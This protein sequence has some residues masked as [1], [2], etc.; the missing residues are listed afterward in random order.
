MGS[1]NRDEFNRFIIQNK[2]VGFFEKAVTLKSGRKSHW[3][4]NWRTISSDA[5]LMDQLISYLISFVRD[6]GLS[7]DS[8]YGVPE[9]ATKLGVL[10]SY[11]WAKGSSDFKPGRFPLPMGRAKPKEHG[12][13]EDRFFVGAP[14]G[15]TVVLEDVTTTGGSLIA[16]LEGLAEAKIEVV[17]AISLTNRMEKTDDGKSVEQA[18]ADMGVRYLCLSEATS[19]LPQA[20]EALKPGEEIAHAIESEFREY[21][22]APV[23]LL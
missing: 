12:V 13:P 16:S 18:I 21:G 9:G 6:A 3:Y 23:R 20:Y 19:F 5:F 1:F 2:V 22:V 14:R 7:P 17:A 15:R 8:F 11:I 4:V 10:A